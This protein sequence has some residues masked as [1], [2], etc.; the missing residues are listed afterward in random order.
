MA[1]NIAESH[2]GDLV[3]LVDLVLPIGSIAT[4]VGYEGPQNLVTM[5]ELPPEE[6]G[7]RQLLAE[8]PLWHFRL[9]AGSPDPESASQ[10]QVGRIGEIID[11][12]KGGY[13][14]VILDLGR[15]LSKFTLPLIQQADLVVLVV[16]PDLSSIT[17]TRTLLDYLHAKGVEN[18]SIYSILNRAVGLEGLSRAEAEKALGL[19][20]RSGIPYLPYFSLA[21]NQ[22]QPYTLKF[23]NESASVAFKDVARQMAEMA[24]HVRGTRELQ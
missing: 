9:L 4:I 2:A 15:S 24:R 21:N 6:A 3:A 11:R 8:L 20:I 23:P 10:L 18:R 22:H 12:L 16:S 13:A 19:E 17:L 1:M 7:T 5:A 14:Y